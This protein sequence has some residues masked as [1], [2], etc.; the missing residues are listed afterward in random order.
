MLAMIQAAQLPAWLLLVLVAVGVAA[1]WALVRHERHAPAPMLPIRFWTNK[2]IA[3]GNFGSFAI[4]AVMMSV[5][6]FLPTYLQGVMGR[7]AVGDRRRAGRHVDQLGRGERAGRPADAAHQLPRQRHAGRRHAG[8]GQRRAGP[9]DAARAAWP[10]R[11]WARC[12]SASA[13]VPA[14]RPTWSRCRRAA[15]LRERGAATASNMFMRIVGQATGAALYGALVN[16][17]IAHYAPHA[18]RVADRLMDPGLR[19]ALGP[20][21]IGDADRGDGGGVAQCLCRGGARRTDRAV[22]GLQAARR[23]SARRRCP[24]ALRAP[25]ADRPRAQSTASAARTAFQGRFVSARCMRMS[26]RD[27]RGPSERAMSKK[28]Q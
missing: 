11:C 8:A 19:Q 21:E 17:G 15:A 28:T 10:G 25:P 7:G 2:V 27:P 20:A 3:L 16:A 18:E 4:G 9:H 14:T 12:S 22:P 5:T 1:L 6:G 13:W 24:T 26:E 23:R